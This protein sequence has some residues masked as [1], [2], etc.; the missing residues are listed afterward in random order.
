MTE[1][2][3]RGGDRIID[4]RCESKLGDAIIIR[5]W[6]VGPKEHHAARFTTTCWCLAMCDGRK[7]DLKFD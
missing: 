5:G 4:R 7:C 1:K 3:G 6:I 2:R